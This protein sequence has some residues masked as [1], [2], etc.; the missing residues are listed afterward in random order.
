MNSVI[1]TV[2]PQPDAD[3]DAACLARRGVPALASPVMVPTYLRPPEIPSPDLT[4]GLIF[5]SRHAIIGFVDLF[6]GTVPRR[7]GRSPYSRSASVR[8]RRAC[9]RV[10]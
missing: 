5:T 7:G 4:G 10:P 8:P 6:G 9:R 1:L 3:L 2:R